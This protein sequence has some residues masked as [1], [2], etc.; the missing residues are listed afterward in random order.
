M[1]NDHSTLARWR[2]LLAVA[3]VA[4]FAA[5]IP[6]QA[7]AQTPA[8]QAPIEQLDAALLAAMKAGQSAPFITRYQKL[9][10]VVERVF[11]LK[12]VLAE[13][14]GFSW[15]T[16]SPEQ[17]GKLEA[18]FRRYTVAT[19]VANFN[20][21][22]GQRFEV[23]PGVRDVGNGEVVV[24]TRLIRRD[25]SPVEL[26]YVMRQDPAGWKVVDVLTNGSISRV[27]VQRADFQE[28]LASGGAP[29]L[30]DGLQRKVATLSGGMVG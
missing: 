10:P 4:L 2:A 13:L 7:T 30:A 26:D 28:M 11:D 9:V 27:A 14:V 22:D 12:Q 15:P 23:L 21:Y 25:K 29:A 1:T 6:W 18:A 3:A 16:L 5:A 20:S 24:R 8:P 19:Y 17:K